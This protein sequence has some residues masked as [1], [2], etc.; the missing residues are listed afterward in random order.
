M[1][2][3][4]IRKLIPC[5]ADRVAWLARHTAWCQANGFVPCSD[6]AIAADA[7]SRT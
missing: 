6:V 5:K 4:T 7:R 3:R 1:D 2:K